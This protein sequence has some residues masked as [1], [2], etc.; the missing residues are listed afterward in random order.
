M[1][2]RRLLA[3]LARAYDLYVIFLP[4]IQKAGYAQGR[5]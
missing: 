5:I 3:S 1:F 4:Q 2:L